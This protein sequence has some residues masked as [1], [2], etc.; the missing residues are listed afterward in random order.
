MERAHR[1]SADRRMSYRFRSR[2]YPIP[3]RYIGR[4]VLCCWP[5]SKFP[6]HHHPPPSYPDVVS[7]YTTK[8]AFTI[9]PLPPPPP[10]RVYFLMN[11][12]ATIGSQPRQ[13]VCIDIYRVEKKERKN[14]T[15]RKISFGCPR[16]TGVSNVLRQRRLLISRLRFF[17]IITR[18][19]GAL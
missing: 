12:L 8:T 7:F 10:R 1:W 9:I 5:P 15:P 3:L 6:A 11:F 4:S 2:L 19:G 18:T 17:I 16:H 13:M 14:S